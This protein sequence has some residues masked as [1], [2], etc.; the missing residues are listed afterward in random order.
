MTASTWRLTA[1]LVMVTA[2][3]LAASR[4]QAS[5]VLPSPPAVVTD[6]PYQ[7]GSW[8]GAE[9]VPID[10]ET[11][12]EIGADR[13]VNRDYM[14]ATGAQASL[15]V[16]Y[17]AQ[18][19][20]GVSIHSPMLCLPGT[21]WDVLSNTTIDVTSGGRGGAVRRMVARKDAAT[22][23]ILYWYAIHGRMV[24]NE[25]MSRAMLLADRVRL[26][27]NDAALVRVVV[28]IGDG[29]EA[30]AERQGLRFVDA[31]VPYLHES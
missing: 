20:P 25:A 24:A 8:R 7:L 19:R 1:A 12:R 18:Q 27:R 31:V 6:L 15:Y 26:G 21:G 9:G 16:A 2:T 29:G 28:P 17:Y 11:A 13:L 23:L 5:A 30:V 22:V 10:A 14:Q 3:A 4:G